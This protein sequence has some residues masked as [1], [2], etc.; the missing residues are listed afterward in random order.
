[1]TK[2]A[3]ITLELRYEQDVVLCRQRVRQVAELLSFDRQEQVRLA[4]AVSEIVRNAFEYAGGGKVELGFSEATPQLFLVTVQD[5]GPGIR[6]LPT[7][8]SGQYVSRTGMGLGILGARRLMEH[9]EIE[10]LPEGGTRVVLGKAIP[11]ASAP[12]TPALIRKITDAL[13]AQ[14]AQNPL[15]EVR[16]QNQEL[17]RALDEVRAKQAELAEL[18]RELEE[19]NR[20]VVALYAELDEK[21]ASLKRAS[22]AKTSFLANMTHEFRTPLNSILGLSRA[23]LSG[24]D[25][26]LNPEHRKQVGFIQKSAETLSELVNDLLDL[27]KVE[28]GKIDVRPE[29]FDLRELMRSLRGVL[30][31]LAG[32]RPEVALLIEEPGD[33]L[34]LVTDEGKLGQILRNLVSNALKYTERGQ[35]RLAAEPLADGSVSFTVSDT[36]IGIAPGNLERIF[37]EFVQIESPLQKQFKGTGLGL[38][39][40]RKLAGLLG[41]S[42][43]V[44]SALHQGSTFTLVVP[45][46]LARPQPEEPAASGAET[47]VESEAPPVPGLTLGAGKAKILIVDDEE[48]ARYLLREILPQEGLQF[49]EAQNGFEGVRLAGREQPDLIFLDLQMPNMSGFYVLELLKANALTRKIPVVVHTAMTLT[50]EERQLLSRDVVAII[51]KDAPSREVARTRIRD[52]LLRARVISELR[53]EPGTEGRQIG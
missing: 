6:D 5:S 28:A 3:F 11:A 50:P 2:R 12:V 9:F 23:A 32:S 10:S 33:A 17:L 51:P 1:V 18:N 43:T 20:G 31:P 34:M 4:T 27:A 24:E 30:K 46:H 13:A 41:G 35:V 42:L 21:A 8:L 36:G 26:Q 48:V 44:T 25:G 45:G 49:I 53:S 47:A 29:S 19:T 14:G 40:S 22:E 38:S 16:E 52:A 39:L 7:V 15:Q 37:D